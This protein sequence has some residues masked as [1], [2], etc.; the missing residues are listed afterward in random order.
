MITVNP[1]SLINPRKSIVRWMVEKPWSEATMISVLFR[2]P[3]F[4]S[5]S[6]TVARS[7]SDDL[8]AA[9]AASDP[10]PLS[11]SDRS[12]SLNQRTEYCGTPSA[13]SDSVKALVVQTSPAAPGVRSRSGTVPAASRSGPKRNS[14][15]S[16]PK[17]GSIPK[18]AMLFRSQGDADRGVARPFSRRQWLCAR[19][20]PAPVRRWS[21]RSG[22]AHG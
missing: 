16:H 6:S 21:G 22:N 1:T 19:R 13:H 11:C 3:F 17:K 8:I 5:T 2:T 15:A 4:S 18:R 9:N 10:G 12:G 14:G 7:A 20:R